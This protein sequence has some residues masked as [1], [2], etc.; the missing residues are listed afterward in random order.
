V[1]AAREWNKP[2]P[3]GDKSCV[4][5]NFNRTGNKVTWTMQCTGQMPMTG[6]GEITFQ[7]DTYAGEI[8]AAANGMNMKIVLSGRKVGTC[9]KPE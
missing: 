7:G 5:S 8:K 3:G 4:S 6:T 9:D 2:P 1:C